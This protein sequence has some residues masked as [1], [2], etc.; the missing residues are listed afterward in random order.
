[1]IARYRGAV[2]AA[3]WLVAYSLTGSAL[4]QLSTTDIAELRER[5]QTEGWTFTVGQNSATARSLNEL[6]GAVPLAELPQ[7]RAVRPI[8]PRQAL[9]ASFDWRDS[10]AC[11][12]IRDQDGCGSCWA[13]ST[14][15]T[16]ECAILRT[17]GT[18]VD[19]SEQWLVSCTGAGSCD[20]GSYITAFDFLSCDTSRSDPCGG[21]GAVLEDELP[22][23][24]DDISCGCPYTH[25][26]CLD[27]YALVDGEW[28]TV[29]QVKQAI[30][31]YGP[32][33]VSVY[34]NSAFVAYTGGVFN[35]CSNRTINHAVVLV[36]WDDTLGANGAWIMRNS[37]GP[38]WGMDGYMYIEYGC[39]RIGYAACY[40][41]YGVEDCNGNG[42]PDDEDIAHGTSEDCQPNGVPDECDIEEGTSLDCQ[43][44][45]VPDECDIGEGT[46]E[47]A[48]GDQV[49][50]E[51]A[52]DCNGNSVPD[53]LDIEGG[54]SLDCQPNGVPDECETDCNGNGVPD[55]CDITDE[56]SPDCQPNGRPD[57]CDIAEGT[58][59]DDDGNGVP[60]EC[61]EDCDENGIWDECDADCGPPGGL[62]DVPGCG[63]IEDCDGNDMP[64]A[65]QRDRDGD[66][67]IDNCDNCL[68]IANASQ[69]DQD[70]DELGDAC[71]NCPVVPNLSQ[72][73]QDGDATGDACDE[74][75]LDPAKVAP[76]ICGCGQ[77]EDP[78]D[79]DGDTWPDCVDG[80]PEDPL[81]T[82]PGLCGCHVPEDSDDWDG[83]QTLDC[84]DRCPY[85]PGKTAPGVCGCGSADDDQD[86]DGVADC[87][88]GC[89][90]DPFKR[91]PGVC[92][93]GFSDFDADGDGTADC[94]DGCS[95]DPAKTTPGDCGCGQ[96][97]TDDDGDNVADCLDNCP[98]T[99][100]PDQRDAD[101]DGVGDACAPAV[102]PVPGESDGA[103]PPEDTGTAPDAVSPAQ[104]SAA[105]AFPC[106]Y[107]AATAGVF[108][109]VLLGAACAVRR[110]YRPRG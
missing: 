75:P 69:L 92:D 15:G 32:L 50:D 37:W 45:E 62:C 21:S 96:P 24:A 99:S 31:D 13:F 18:E 25:P 40:V 27:G 8:T 74:C 48:D 70:T 4:G 22:Y 10:G 33:S 34:V 6:C 109:L 63:Q 36:G 101:G 65:C 44:N 86:G 81:K 89:P 84:V 106:G 66:E 83:D 35:A 95:S 58:S 16:M 17:D 60:D 9:P 19:L 105:P 49:P 11:T 14:M 47:D 53:G 26:Y 20:G 67:V 100:N 52:A 108:C 46:S 12:P 64:D 97:D 41:R 3:V 38:D 28:P 88:D 79:T 87:H 104:G 42:S 72:T 68:V 2:G 56:T 43:P 78:A 90:F 93:C 76:G 7:Q 85:D 61:E 102:R 30:L 110:R 103:T 23:E 55:D 57:E 29:E 98:A 73:D 1:M 107:G 51:C 71:D 77:A 59:P 5:A 80:C 82:E 91:E 39:S 94:L 54:T